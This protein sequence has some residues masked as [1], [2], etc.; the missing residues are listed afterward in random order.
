MPPT[1]ENVDQEESNRPSRGDSNG[2]FSGNAE[3]RRCAFDEYSAVE[4]QN[5]QFDK[6]ISHNCELEEYESNLVAGQ[7]DEYQIRAVVGGH[8]FSDSSCSAVI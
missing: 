6:A 5:A 2:D 4:K 3:L 1:E 7:F 8:T